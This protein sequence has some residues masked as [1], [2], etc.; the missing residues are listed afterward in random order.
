VEKTSE[1]PKVS[2]IIPTYNSEGTLLE[3]LKAVFNQSYPFYE[4]IIVDSFSN[5]HTVRIAK[6]FGVK[7]IEQK[8]SPASAR[9]I[10]TAN[11][12]GK[13]VFFLDS[14]Q[15]LSPYV[16]EECVKM[17]EDENIGMVSIPEISVGKGFWG[18]CS[19]SW[20]N[21]YSKVGRSYVGSRAVS[22]A[23]R[24]FAKTF[25]VRVG[26]LTN[27]LLWGEDRDLHERL[28]RAGVKEAF[29]ISK[30]YHNELTSIRS[31]LL[32]NLRY[33]KSIPIF[34]Q[35]PQKQVFPSLLNHA[36]LTIKEIF[37][38]S[39]DDP[40]LVIGCVILFCLKTYST[41]IGIL[42]NMFLH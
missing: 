38:D 18:S 12:T 41:M 29:C 27:N 24:F 7:I 15:V 11:S 25:I 39:K 8:C 21:Y 32:K 3:C 42:I 19:A 30:V 4:V 5:D 28:Q 20:K 13:Y 1:K 17:C 35:R 22:N 16:V 40:A 9:N 34:L 36:W 14:D 23:P 31:I 2:I 6:E 26:M 37:R 10:G 33:G